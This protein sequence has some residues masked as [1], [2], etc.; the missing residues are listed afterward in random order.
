MEV[1]EEPKDGE[2]AESAGN[3]ENSVASE[4]AEATAQE[5]PEA[6]D[7]P[8]EVSQDKEQLPLN[9]AVLEDSRDSIEDKLSQ[10]EG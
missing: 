2:G 6:K 7:E 9:D 1:L 10:M 3:G 5:A 8:M 4:S